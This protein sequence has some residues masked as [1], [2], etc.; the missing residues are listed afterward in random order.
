MRRFGTAGIRGPVDDT[1]TPQLALAVGRAAAEDGD[2]FVVG[3]DARPTGEGLADAVAAGLESGGVD[4]RR[5]GRVPTPTLGFA[6]RSRRGVMV[7]ASHNP[8]TDNGLKLFVDGVEYDRTAE[9]RVADRLEDVRNSRRWDEW[10][11]GE[12][13]SVLPRYREAVVEYATDHGPDPGHLQIAVDCG[14][15][16]AGL[17]TPQVLTSLG[18]RVHAMNAN[19]DGHVPARASK[20]T[21]ESLADLRAYVADSDCDFGL[22]HDGDGDRLVVVN[23]TGDVVHEDTVLAVIANHYVS[24]SVAGDPVVV[25][26]PNASGRIDDHVAAAGGRVE[27]VRLGALHEGIAAVRDDADPGTDVVFAAE[28]W[29]HIHP[30]FGGWIDATTSAAVLTRIVA[31]SGLDALADPV[32]DRPYRKLSLECPDN[33]KDEA[34]STIADRLPD[35]FP[36]A[37]VDGAR[38]VRL[39]FPDGDW[40]LVRP[41]GTEPKLRLYVE[42]DDV[43]ELVADVRAVVEDAI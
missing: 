29:K 27:R 38:G 11:D 43:D 12:T 2:E 13:E 21:A 37:D 4:V 41:S 8:P 10:G 22:G 1:V 32:D 6:S 9:R 33:R 20:P 3:W 17:A 14:S 39:D 30:G 28:P 7:T 34:M 23:A 16:T 26:T 24:R 5:I 40:V 15:G 36:D 31:D 42:S 25:T 19:P 18:A 35:R